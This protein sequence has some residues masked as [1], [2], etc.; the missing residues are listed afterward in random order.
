[1]ARAAALGCAAVAVAGTLAASQFVL[2]PPVCPVP[3]CSR[4]SC[5]VSICSISAP[6]G[7]TDASVL[8]V[9]GS[10]GL[11]LEVLSSAMMRC[12]F[13]RLVLMGYA[14]LDEARK[15]D[16]KMGGTLFR[17]GEVVNGFSLRPVK[18]HNDSYLT[19]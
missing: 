4:C 15:S 5:S 12:S 13:R 3:D 7:H 9:E 8:V 18:R 16:V 17:A 11:P 19:R 10:S 6:N 2:A 1:M 14:D